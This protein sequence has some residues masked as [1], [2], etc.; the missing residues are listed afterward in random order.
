MDIPKINNGE[1]GASIRQKLNDTIDRSNEQTDV[2]VGG[3]AGQVLR[4]TGNDDL[5][6]DW[7]T[8]GASDVGAATGDHTHGAIANNGHVDAI[9]LNEETGF[10]EAPDSN[11]P[12]RVLDINNL[13][14][15]NRFK[16]IDV[17]AGLA[18]SFSR[19]DGITYSATSQVAE[20]ST[21]S[22]NV[23]ANTIQMVRFI[24]NAD[25]TLSQLGLVVTGLSSGASD[26]CRIVIYTSLTGNGYP[27]D[28]FYTSPEIGI[29][30]V[31]GE[32]FV[33]T[34]FAQPMLRRGETYWFGIHIQAQF[35]TRSKPQ[36][37]VPALGYSGLNASFTKIV[38]TG[39][40]YAGGAPATW[41][42]DESDLSGGALP[43]VRYRHTSMP[44]GI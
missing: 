40:S 20:G 9:P 10:L 8:L 29:G 17:A 13:V 21:T 7:E 31:T 38:R 28:L 23:N 25:I 37:S 15:N 32:K 16:A 18:G 41:N 3:T 43:D 33:S 19:L 36:S 4:K 12:A 22:T 14:A 1:S 35:G 11:N 6:I 2:L 42:F 27:S 26:T 5:E 39:I 30:D 24:P 34:G 44:I